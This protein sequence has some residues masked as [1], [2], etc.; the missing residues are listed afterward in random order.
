MRVLWDTTQSSTSLPFSSFNFVLPR[1]SFSPSF[2]SSI[3]ASSLSFLSKTLSWWWNSLFHGWFPSG[4]C[5]L[6]PLPL[7]L[8]LHLHGEKSPL[9][10]LIEVQWSNLHRSLT[11]KLPSLFPWNILKT[12]VL[13]YT[14]IAS[15]FFLSSIVHCRWLQWLPFLKG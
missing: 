3:E 10:D 6:S 13:E 14:H 12:K 2:F 9:K 11:R 15:S 5:L 7:Y 1:F 8:P 4:W